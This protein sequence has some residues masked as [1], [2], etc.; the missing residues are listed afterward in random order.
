VARRRLPE[1]EAGGAVA[2]LRAELEAAQAAQAAAR[3]EAASAQGALEREQQAGRAQAAA[4][5]AAGQ[6]A[7]QRELD[8]ARRAGEDA[9]RA[10][11]AAQAQLAAEQA[12][13]AEAAADARAQVAAEAA[14][15]RRAEEEAAAARGEAQRAEE[16]AQAQAAQAQARDAAAEAQRAQEQARQAL[17]PQCAAGVCSIGGLHAARGHSAAPK[18][19]QAVR[20]LA[21]VGGARGA[22]RRRATRG[23]ARPPPRPSSCRRQPRALPRQPSSCRRRRRAPPRQPSRLLARL[24]RRHRARRRAPPSRCWC[25]RAARPRPRQRSPCCCLVWVL[26]LTM[27]LIAWRSCQPRRRPHRPQR[28]QPCLGSRATKKRVGP[29]VSAAR[30]RQNGLGVV[31]AGALA[32]FLYLQRREAAAA[33]AAADAQLAGQ[34]ASL[35][36]LRTQARATG[37]PGSLHAQ[38]CTEQSV[39]GRPVGGCAGPL[40]ACRASCNAGAAARAPG[41]LVLP[42]LHLRVPAHHAL[43]LGAPGALPTTQAWPQ[44]DEATTAAGRERT[45]AGQ[46]RQ[47][48]SAANADSARQARRSYPVGALPACRVL[49]T[50]GALHARSRPPTQASISVQGA[51]QANEKLAR[52]GITCATALTGERRAAAPR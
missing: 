50:V 36:G 43:S 34:R 46:L 4:S 32:G 17:R 10:A 7:L 47:Q 30:A 33:Q 39:S 38:H 25:G 20:R 27:M 23:S 35:A 8:A 48:L 6:Q 22:G 11:A 12:A 24:W 16:A 42:V 2:R 3:A 14:A 52:P 5:Q 45:L 9:Q 26:I 29:A 44:V 49:T 31:A 41:T 19:R 40:L 18:Q 28:P 51:S 21:D 13:A 15:A 37:C 1:A